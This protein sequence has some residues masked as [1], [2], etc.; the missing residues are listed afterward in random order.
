MKTN[1]NNSLLFPSSMK[2]DEDFYQKQ[3]T[4]TFFSSNPDQNLHNFVSLYICYS[5]SSLSKSIYNTEGDPNWLV[6]FKCSKCKAEW[7]TCRFCNYQQQPK[8][9][10]VSKRLLGRMSKSSHQ[11]LLE[12]IK[13][14][15]HIQHHVDVLKKQN[16]YSHNSQSL[17]IRSI[18]KNTLKRECTFPKKEIPEGHRECDMKLLKT[19]NGDVTKGKAVI[20]IKAEDTEEYA[21][22]QKQFMKWNLLIAFPDTPNDKG[23]NCHIRTILEQMHTK[24]NYAEYLIRKCWVKNLFCSITKEDCNLFIRIVKEFIFSSRDACIRQTDIISRMEKRKFDQ[25]HFLEEKIKNLEEEIILLKSHIDLQSSLIKEISIVDTNCMH[26]QSE[27]T[28]LG[29]KKGNYS[30]RKPTINLPLPTETF[31]IKKILNGP[32]S[33]VGNLLIPPIYHLP[34]GYTYVLPSQVLKLYL[35]HGIEFNYMKWNNLQQELNVSPRSIFNSHD[36]IQKANS[37]LSREKNKNEDIYLLPIG[38]WSDG[39]DAGGASKSLRNVVKAITIHIPHD[40]ISKNHVFLVGL[41]INKGDHDQIRKIIMEDFEKLEKGP[42]PCYLPKLNKTVKVQIFLSYVIFDRVEHCDWTGFMGH[43]GIFSTIPGLSCPIVTNDKDKTAAKGIKVKKV[44]SSCQ[45]C[46]YRRIRL[47]KQQDFNGASSSSTGCSK[48]NDWN[49][50]E[51]EFSHDEYPVD[52]KDNTSKWLK[53]LKINF[54]EMVS[55]CETVHR[56]V[57]FHEWSRKDCDR[58]AQRFCIK[59]E[60]LNKIFADA[61]SRRPKKNN[62]PNNN[63]WARNVDF[64]YH[65]LPYGMRQKILDLDDCI[66]GIM[67]TLV[68]NLGR[69]FLTTIQLLSSQIRIWSDKIYP[70]LKEKLS[71]IGSLSLNWCKALAFGSKEKPASPWVSENYLAFIT[72][73]KSLVS[74]FNFNV[75]EDKNEHIKTLIMVT[76]STFNIIISYVFQ[77]EVPTVEICNMVDTYAKIFLSCYRKLDSLIEKKEVNVIESTACAINILKIGNE[78]RRKGMQRKFWEGGILGEGYIPIVKCDLRRGVKMKGS[79]PSAVR[80]IYQKKSLDILRD[81]HDSINSH[82]TEG[83]EDTDQDED[84][85]NSFFTT[86]RYRKF[87]CYKNIDILSNDINAYKAVAVVYF[88]A[89][90]KIYGMIRISNKRNLLHIATKCHREIMKTYCFDVDISTSTPFDMEELSLSCDAYYSALL[91]PINFIETG[92]SNAKT[93]KYYMC[94]ENRMEYNKERKF[95]HPSFYYTSKSNLF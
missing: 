93:T 24:N 1:L 42:I 84:S 73:G 23:A 55:C 35:A 7:Y 2:V 53:S 59:K 89:E 4:K 62:I 76:M 43:N 39:F 63:N 30:N 78:M 29:I 11:I 45:K 52:A 13:Q 47:L 80:K 72:I 27:N 67:H 65:F 51:V 86:D 92:E 75:K 28:N 12:K 36:I 8:N 74:M 58:Y 71:H 26:P 32:N 10:S 90:K 68:L 79:I 54:K 3:I 9:P 40:K 94:N 19:Q 18:E 64:P 14:D 22:K 81:H 15:H 25:Q 91:L 61:Y 41:G 57:Y 85:E 38:L 20:E 49:L 87:H 48:C 95:Q 77:M 46:Y 16:P 60:I 37:L 88:K 33:F 82:I 6:T 83:K 44:I 5:C 50:N 21:F 66:V 70:E 17:Q 34:D 31:H 69:H 56:K